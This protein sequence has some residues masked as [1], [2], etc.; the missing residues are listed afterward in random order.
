V[1]PNGPDDA[2]TFHFDIFADY[3]QV[4][5]DECHLADELTAVEGRDP[6]VR[7][8]EIAAHV[9]A[10]LSPEAFARHLGVAHGTLCILTGRYVEVP[11]TVQI[12]E[13]APADDFI[14][15]RVIRL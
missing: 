13:A 10:V 12:R 14:R 5:L 9:A 6:L 3:H 15:R 4:S 2:R 8:E 7:A 1:H 11:V